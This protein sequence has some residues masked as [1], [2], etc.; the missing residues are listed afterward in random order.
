[1]FEELEPV[2]TRLASLEKALIAF[3]DNIE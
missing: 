1:M 2:D 3:L